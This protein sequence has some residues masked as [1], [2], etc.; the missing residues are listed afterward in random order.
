MNSEIEVMQNEV[1]SIATQIEEICKT[2]KEIND[3]YMGTQ[4]YFSPLKSQMDLMFIGIN[5]GAGSFKHNEDGI[6]PRKTVPLEKSEYET[7][8]YSLQREWVSVFGKDFGI[9]NLDL[10]YKSFKTNCCFLATED[11]QKL[12]KLKSK[13]KYTYK[14]DF[15]FNEKRWIKTLIDFVEPKIIICEGFEAFNY[16]TTFF[17]DEEL[18]I[19]K[20][21]ELPTRKVADLQSGCIVLGFKRIYSTLESKDIVVETLEEMMKNII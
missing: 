2:D 21:E 8:E 18:K 5:P 16:F 15:A 7:E 1:D 19:S 12:K 11:S 10:L 3:L 20:E 14:M 9:N 17:S 4:V 6:K 13:L